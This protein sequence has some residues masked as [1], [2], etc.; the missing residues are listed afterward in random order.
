MLSDAASRTLL[1]TTLTYNVGAWALTSRNWYNYIDSH[2]IL[3]ALPFSFLKEKL[4]QE[5]NVGAIIS[6]NMPFERQYI[7]TPTEEWRELGVEHFKIDIPDFIS[8]PTVAQMWEGIELIK[9]KAEV[10]QKTYVHCKAGRSRSATMVT[11]YVMQKY[12]KNVE[13][14][15]QFVTE[16]R[17]H[18][19][20]TEL[21]LQTLH[22][23]ALTLSQPESQNGHSEQRE[24]S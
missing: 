9:A 11:A 3:G 13:E 4:V 20:Y 2:V 5:E 7:T 22:D 15:V 8:T 6:L 17:P 21:Q 10:G 16:K 19:K 1:Y 24:E 18:V 14:A 12:E 23:F